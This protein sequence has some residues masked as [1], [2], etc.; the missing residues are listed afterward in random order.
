MAFT[1]GFQGTLTNGTTPVTLVAAPPERTQ[2]LVRKIFIQN[3]DTVN[4]K[5]T[6]KHVTSG[7]STFLIHEETLVAGSQKTLEHLVLDKS[8][9]TI[10]VT[11]GAAVTTTELSCT[12]HFADL[13]P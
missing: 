1:P 11:L 5:V 2:R 3:A 7:G 10:T 13:G 9:Q 6:V 8:T 12:A 4:A